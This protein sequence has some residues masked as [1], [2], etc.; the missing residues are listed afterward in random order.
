MAQ[1]IAKRRGHFQSVLAS[2]VEIRT[3]F[4]GTHVAAD[5]KGGST[6]FYVHALGRIMVKYVYVY[7][8]KFTRSTRT[9]FLFTHKCSF[10]AVLMP[11]FAR[12]YS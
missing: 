1:P 3:P 7:Y 6:A 9:S 4:E 5:E 11:N 2:Y 12:K 10:S 8:F